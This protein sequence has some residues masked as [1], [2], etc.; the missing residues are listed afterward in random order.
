MAIY[1]GLH[2]I[3]IF[4]TE[5]QDIYEYSECENTVLLTILINKSM[6]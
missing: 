6:N 1:K 5:L 3:S 2:W 4:K